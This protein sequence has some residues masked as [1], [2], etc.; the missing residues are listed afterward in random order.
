MQIIHQSQPVI[1][2]PV[3]YHLSNILIALWRN[4]NA[5]EIRFTVEHQFCQKLQRDH[6]KS[7]LSGEY[8]VILLDSLTIHP[9]SDHG[10]DRNASGMLLWLICSC[11]SVYLG[12]SSSGLIHYCYYLYIT[13][14][15]YFGARYHSREPISLIWDGSINNWYLYHQIF[16]QM[17]TSLSTMPLYGIV[18]VINSLNKKL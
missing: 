16:G 15:V 12:T 5:C 9:W 7:P 11:Y 2:M 14:G 6:H 13:A 4:R 3:I 8:F 17:K 1:R 10:S 18:I